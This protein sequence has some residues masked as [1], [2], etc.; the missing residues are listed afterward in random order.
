[1]SKVVDPQNPADKLHLPVLREKEDPPVSIRLSGT[2]IT[3][4]GKLTTHKYFE[5]LNMDFEEYDVEYTPEEAR[6]IRGHLS[7]MSTGSTSMTPQIC[8]PRCPWKDRCV[9]YSMNKAPL[10]LPC[11]IEVNLLREWTTAYFNEYKVEPTNFTEITM[12]SELAEIEVLLWRINMGL[13]RAENVS[14]TIEQ[15]IGVATNGEPINQTQ[16]SPLYELKE[17]LSARKTKLVKL[18]VGDRQEKYKK[19]AAL[20]KSDDSDPS[21]AMANIRYRLE[22]VQRDMKA[23]ER[24][25]A[26]KSGQIIEAKVISPEDIISNEE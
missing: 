25:L 22:R 12:I 13:S 6:K 20:R 5:F 7:K 15:M 1:M 24:A 2:A 26:E 3:E 21:S 9:F 11:L 8:S 10:G 14:M 16:V 18:L 19:E 4:S 17:R 23:T